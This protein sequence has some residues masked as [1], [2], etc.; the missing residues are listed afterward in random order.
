MQPRH[1]VPSD[2]RAPSPRICRS[3]VLRQLAAD[4][5]HT[6][7]G[8]LIETRLQ[9]VL[10]HEGQHPLIDV[11]HVAIE[12]TQARIACARHEGGHEPARHA[13]GLDADRAGHGFERPF[14]LVMRDSA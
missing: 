14:E 9:S 11:E 2:A 3:C 5:L 6:P 10:A 7:V 8:R 13:N 12:M 1:T 4:A